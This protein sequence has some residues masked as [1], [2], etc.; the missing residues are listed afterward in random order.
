MSLCG[1]VEIAHN[2]ILFTW[3][4]LKDLKDMGYGIRIMTKCDYN[5]HNNIIGGSVLG[6]VDNTRFNKDEWIKIDNNIFFVNK[7]SDVYYARA[8]NTQ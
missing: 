2:T 6:G 8:S 4:R 7:T 1:N 3:S 5:I